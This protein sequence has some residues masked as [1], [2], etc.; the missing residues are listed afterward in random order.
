MS[1]FILMFAPNITDWLIGS[2]GWDT[3]QVLWDLLDALFGLFE[4]LVPNK[5]MWDTVWESLFT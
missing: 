5:P 2:F 3:M 4:F 1:M